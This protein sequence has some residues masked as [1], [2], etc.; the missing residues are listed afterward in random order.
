MPLRFNDQQQSE[1]SRDHRRYP[2]RIKRQTIHC[3]KTARNQG[4]A[5]GRFL[6][7]SRL[8]RRGSLAKQ[9]VRPRSVIMGSV[10]SGINFFSDPRY[11]EQMTE[12]MLTVIKHARDPEKDYEGQTRRIKKSQETNGRCKRSDRFMVRID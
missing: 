5:A 2:A 8:R 11:K 9:R 10:C 7:E 1:D 12:M 3:R 4:K 6:Q